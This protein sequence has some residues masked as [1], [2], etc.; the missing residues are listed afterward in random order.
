MSNATNYHQ[1]SAG[2]VILTISFQ[3][4]LFKFNSKNNLKRRNWQAWKKSRSSNTRIGLFWR[5]RRGGQIVWRV[6]RWPGGTLIDSQAH[7]Y[8]RWI[9]CN[10][11]RAEDNGYHKRLIGVLAATRRRRRILER[12]FTRDQHDFLINSVQQL[13]ETFQK[14]SWI[15][16]V[17]LLISTSGPFN[18][19]KVN[20]DVESESRCRNYRNACIYSTRQVVIEI[21]FSLSSKVFFTEKGK[22]SNGF[23]SS[24][25]NQVPERLVLFFLTF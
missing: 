21:P 3:L 16:S 9:R 5:T 8:N 23:V 19:R 14:L 17:I 11:T 1:K 13:G 24:K 2:L 12:T 10:W 15:L 4:K 18:L 20:Q 6:M 7:C 25:V 22:F